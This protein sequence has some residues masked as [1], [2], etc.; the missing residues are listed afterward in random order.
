M[1]RNITLGYGSGGRLTGE[2]VKEIFAGRFGMQGPL[3]DS[4][5][6]ENPGSDLAF[7]TDSYV[8]EPLFFPGGNIGKLAVCGTVN[9]LAVSGAIPVSLSSAFIIEENFPWDELD[10]IAASM[11][12]EAARAGVRIVTGDTKVVG[13]GKCD[14]LFITTS[15]IGKIRKGYENLATAANVRQDDLLIV[16]GS[17]GNHSIAVLAARNIF[18]FR[19]SVVSDVASLNFLAGKLLEECHGIHFMR[20]ITR[21]GLA[22]VMNELCAMSGLGAEIEEEKTPVD[23]PV[24]G[25]CEILGFDPY[26]LANEGK[27][28]VVCDSNEASRALEIMQKDTL[29]KNAAIIGRVT[30]DRRKIVVLNTIAGGKRILDHRSGLQLPR[31]C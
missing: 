5:V 2:L 13:K 10:E 23:E 4:S 27:M 15:G 8:V 20:D 19:T 17:M 16:N 18:D 7:T 30:D 26:Y 9:D 14:R 31:I 24:K 21:G 3:T 28:L 6:L 29:G 1:N 22:S 25:L 12:D 11:A